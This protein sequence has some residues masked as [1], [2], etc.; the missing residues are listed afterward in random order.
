MP[1]DYSAFT[2][3]DMQAE[4][5]AIAR[6]AHE[7][8]GGF[9]ERELNWKPNQDR[10]SVA[11]CLDHLLSTDRLMFEAM[12]GAMDPL[13]RRG[14]VERVPILPGF[15]GR[16]M[17]RSLGPQ[18]SRRFTA[19]RR[20]VPSASALDPAIVGTFIYHQA[21]NARRVG[22]F[23]DARPERVIMRSPFA[24][25]PYSVLDACRIVCAHERRH[26]EQAK[27]VTLEAAFPRLH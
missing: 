14:L 21:E 22:E 25:I 6:E 9:G 3:A 2:I 1:V 11:Q 20:A 26:F 5:A 7:A 23:G 24:P 4:F 18:V 12:D 15:F 16:M 17:V 13:R 27:R 10:W 8:F 19:P